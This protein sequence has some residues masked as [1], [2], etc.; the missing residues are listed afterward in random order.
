[1]G[2]GQLGGVGRGFSEFGRESS[3]AK[4]SSESIFQILEL[5]DF[6]QMFK[7]GFYAVQIG[8]IKDMLQF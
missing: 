5:S 8:H 6:H 1:M 3:R 7:S 4:G 2:D